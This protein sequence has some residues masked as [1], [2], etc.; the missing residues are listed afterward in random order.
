MDRGFEITGSL[1]EGQFDECAACGR[2]FTDFLNS[3]DAGCPS[4]YSYF[5]NTAREALA[6]ILPV[7]ERP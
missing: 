5:R 6:G 2:S 1:G 3:Q 7:T 4:C